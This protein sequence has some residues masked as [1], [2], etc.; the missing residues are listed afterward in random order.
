MVVVL[1]FMVLLMKNRIFVGTVGDYGNNKT[2][3]KLL[4]AIVALGVVDVGGRFDMESR[5]DLL[6]IEGGINKKVGRMDK[7]GVK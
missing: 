1:F 5:L 4:S 2:N 6:K 3:G 7:K